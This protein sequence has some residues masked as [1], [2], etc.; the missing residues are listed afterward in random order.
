MR[1]LFLF[2]F[3]FV[4]LENKGKISGGVIVIELIIDSGRESRY[5]VRVGNGQS[6][7]WGCYDS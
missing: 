1:V 4:S 5:R 3:F 2:S 6:G 7:V